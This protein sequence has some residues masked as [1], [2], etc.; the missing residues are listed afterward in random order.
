MLT[1]PGFITA[2]VAICWL[3]YR[4]RPRQTGN[5]SNMSPDTVSSLFP[6][7][8]IRPLP[9]RRLRERL[10]PEVAD[11]IKYPPSTYA[12]LPLFHYPPYSLK[13]EGSSPRLESV[14][15]TEVGRRTESSQSSQPIRRNGVSVRPGE[16]GDVISRSTLVTRS[17]PEILSRASV[18]SP[19]PEQAR[20]S[21][22]QPPPSVTSSVDGYDSF[23]NTNNK[24]KRKI[25]TA[26]D[27]NIN[28]GH[29]ISPDVTAHATAVDAQSPISDVGGDRSYYNSVGYASP[30]VFGPGG[31][32]MSGSGRGRLGRSRNGRS[33][34]RALPDG[35]N[36]WAGRAPKS[37][38]PHWTT[39]GE[40]SF[41]Y[42]VPCSSS[43][44]NYSNFDDCNRVCTASPGGGTC[45]LH[46]SRWHL[47][48]LALRRF[49]DLSFYNCH[50][51]F[52]Q[53][54]I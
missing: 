29:G 53:E 41:L 46:E 25:P 1:L 27:S 44:C 40:L 5:S 38:P 12:S 16:D 31:T 37:F 54:L 15:P 52:A 30:G 13:D 18:R 22:N 35:N 3:T 43:M 33:P 19:R 7:R 2:I 36:T 14:S 49:H 23:E 20:Q 39:G 51:N 9:R 47:N 10:S 45:F 21:H 42:L 34:L 8:P 24:K 32:G 28:N 26:G 50:P 6:D 4:N 17:P 11:A 48:L